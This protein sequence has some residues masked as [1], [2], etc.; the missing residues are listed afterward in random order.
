MRSLTGRLPVKKVVNRNHYHL[1][2]FK[3]PAMGLRCPPVLFLCTRAYS[4][5][6]CPGAAHAVPRWR[7]LCPHGTGPLFPSSL[8]Q[9][10][11]LFYGGGGGSSSSFGEED[12]YVTLGVPPYASAEE[13]KAA[14]KKLALQYHPDRNTEPG[15]EEK[16]KAIAA[17]YSVIGNKKSRQQYDM[18]RQ[19]ARGGGGS[20]GA[21]GWTPHG[22]AAGSSCHVHHD[23]H[24]HH[25]AQG[26][27]RRMSKEEA[28]QMFREMFGTFRIDDIFRAFEEESRRGG[29]RGSGTGTGFLGSDPA[30]ASYPGMGRG[31][32][33]SFFGTGGPASSSSSS[34]RSSSTRVYYDANG[35]RMEEHT[36]SG[37]SGTYYRVS[38]QTTSGGGAER[39]GAGLGSSGRGSAQTGGTGP[40]GHPF[41]S[42]GPGGSR[43]NDPYERV[44]STRGRSGDGRAGMEAEPPHGEQEAG[45]FGGM[46]YGTPTP[47]DIRRV[48][49]W[50]TVR[51]MAWIVI[52]TMFIWM[53]LSTILFHPVLM[54]AILFLIAAGRRGR[55]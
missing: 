1:I 8:C 7:S 27:Y 25:H 38:Q 5:G 18:E 17:A 16:F 12:H 9:Q 52:I 32:F 29:V 41:F 37:P 11:R 14:Y 3:S 55:L 50:M 54:L 47:I 36:F 40:H 34:A 45:G 21:G 44:F 22:S 24:H 46:P 43:L 30:S 42:R 35:N 4:V 20:G 48:T 15:A 10:R 26:S 6:C 51:F 31:G 33:H 28:D 13:I 23:H 39:A 2:Y 19:F 49:F 53:I